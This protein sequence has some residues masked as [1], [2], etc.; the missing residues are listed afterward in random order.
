MTKVVTQ[1]M[2]EEV[3]RAVR[4]EDVHA[5]KGSCETPVLKRN[6]IPLLSTHP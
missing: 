1:E 6:I 5:N 2:Q 3:A 4:F